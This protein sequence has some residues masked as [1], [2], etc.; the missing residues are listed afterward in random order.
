M[1]MAEIAASAR[2]QPTRVNLGN[3]IRYIVEIY[4]TDKQKMPSVEPVTSMQIPDTN[5]LN[6]RNARTTSGSSTQIYNMQATYKRTQS[7]ISDVE[8]PTPGTYT[9]PS[10]T[11]RY[12]GQTLTIPS[13]KLEVLKRGENAAPTVDELVFLK[14]EVPQQMYIGQTIEMDLQL[15]IDSSVR[16]RRIHSFDRTSDGFVLSELKNDSEDSMQNYKGRRY[17]VDTWPLTLTPIQ[18]GLQDLSFQFRISAQFPD[19]SG[20]NSP[21]GQRS[22]FG[23]S[24]FDDF[25][26]RTE[27]F[28]V[29][30]EPLQVE[31]LPLPEADKPESFSGAIGDFSLQV[32]SDAKSS[33]V[34]EPVML[35]VEIAGS[36]NFD[37]IEGPE[38]AESPA[39]RSYKPES[40][41][42]PSDA[43]GL[44]GK[45]RFDYICIP[46]QAGSQ[47]LPAVR[48]SFFDPKSKQYIE[49]D[50]PPIPMEVA[51]GKPGNPS[52]GT[53]NGDA[54]PLNGDTASA[55]IPKLSAEEALL[56]L[57]YRPRASRTVDGNWLRQPLFY[58]FHG[59]IALAFA[60]GIV[61]LRQRRKLQ[62]DHS[63]RLAREA[64]KAAKAALSEAM[65]SA[66]A[67]DSES[68]YASAC[69]SIRLAAT[70]ASG[71]DLRNADYPE[72]RP[73]LRSE[74]A[75]EACESLFQK[76]DT[77]RYSGQSQ[78]A[79][80][81]ADRQK[82]E[83]ILKAL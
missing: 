6:V 24:I 35:S 38:L 32:Y 60:F 1:A 10:Y 22:P 63:Y 65:A 83:S 45:K 15:Y 75:A 71:K 77:I 41:F 23:G 69:R 13:A 72:I 37:R 18:T 47:E 28:N 16:L 34:G 61:R 73:C 26:G 68:F 44:H 58:V 52:A 53:L 19:Q 66:T 81:E 17:Q 4:E 78:Q 25:F 40:T 5:G 3:P 42:V 46:Q 67:G 50:S 12:K 48:F 74:T 62:Q 64:G 20:T 51:P 33:R 30:T 57:D 79:N 49:L 9:I 39:W 80:L 14:A 11:I 70:E 54:H 27:Q 59:T 56:V 21:F 36:G 82:L 55:P 7:I 31:V 29:Y 43:I 2:F 8:A 76:A